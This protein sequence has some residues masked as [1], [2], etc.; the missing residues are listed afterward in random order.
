LPF[1]INCHDIASCPPGRK[2]YIAVVLTLMRSLY[3]VPAYKERS[4]R[5]NKILETKRPNILFIHGYVTDATLALL[6]LLAMCPREWGSFPGK[7]K[8]C[9]SPAEQLYR[10]CRP[11][12][13]LLG[14]ERM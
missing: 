6:T 1:F 14:A 9:F 4:K 13:L 5:L 10:P 3:F 7:N 2:E 12:F 11:F 8:I